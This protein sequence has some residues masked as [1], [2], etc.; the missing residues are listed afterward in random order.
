M[1]T[2]RIQLTTSL[3]VNGHFR[4][5][6]GLQNEKNQ[7]S[8]VCYIAL[9]VTK[10]C[11]LQCAYCFE[12]AP[13][14]PKVQMRDSSMSLATVSQTLEN[15]CAHTTRQDLKLL[16]FGGEPLLVGR[17][18]LTQATTRAREI[19]A[20]YGKEFEI[21]I[22]TNGTLLTDT[23]AQTLRDLRIGVCVSVD[24]PPALHDQSRGGGKRVIRGIEALLR[25]G[26]EPNVICI[27]SPSN[28]HAIA[29]ILAFFEAYNIRRGRISPMNFAGNAACGVEFDNFDDPIHAVLSVLD[30]MIETQCDQFVDMTLLRRINMYYDWL[31]GVGATA[32]NYDCYT[33]TCWA[34]E[35][36]LAVDEQGDMY[37][38]SRC[39]ADK[40]KLGNVYASV[41]TTRYRSPAIHELHA[42][43]MEYFDCDMCPS[44]PVCFAGCAIHNK[45]DERNFILDCL[46][47]KRI[48]ASFEARR[49][50]IVMLAE[51]MRRQL[52]G[53]GTPPVDDQNSLLLMEYLDVAGLIPIWA[54]GGLLVVAKDG[55]LFLLDTEARRA[56]QIDKDMYTYLQSAEFT[57]QELADDEAALADAM[58]PHTGH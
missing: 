16:F 23:F 19:A 21:A 1:S 6:F 46:L 20:T 52:P 36:Y 56:F 55:Q 44:K 42:K 47:T 51:K 9:H 15:V 32:K 39:V 41:E 13:L 49:L 40:Y 34:G 12:S 22:T 4:H 18:W 29:D 25:A 43:G 17:S 50:D 37:P 48:W 10:Y 31:R 3:P 11:N 14:L 2:Q 30:Y 45:Q 26:I 53:L 5:R 54:Q 58:L 28:V 33:R 27:V 35:G 57:G 38:C 8:D 7:Y 24:G